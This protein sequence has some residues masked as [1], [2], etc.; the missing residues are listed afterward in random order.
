[1]Y[2][3]KQYQRIPFNQRRYSMDKEKVAS[4]FAFMGGGGLITSLAIT[5][6]CTYEGIIQYPTV[7]ILIPGFVI[8]CTFTA[9][10]VSMGFSVNPGRSKSED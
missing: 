7:H 6:I 1:M 5:L 2:C 4:N 9:I 3:F 10:G 8:A